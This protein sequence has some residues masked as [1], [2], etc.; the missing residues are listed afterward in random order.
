MNNLDKKR[1]YGELL[2][3]TAAVLWGSCFSFQKQ[4]MNFYGPFTLGA[5]RFFLG[6]IILIP[7]IF[8]FAKIKLRITDA[9]VDD[10]FRNKTLWTGGLISALVLFSAVTLQQVGL[11][12]TTA[13][14]AAFLTS[15]E[16][17]VVEVIGSFLVRRFNIK[18]FFGICFAI[19]GM[20]LLCVKNGLSLQLGDVLELAGA[21]FWGIQILLAD[22]YSK[23]TDAIKFSFI[24]FILVGLFSAVGMILFEK[25]DMNDI[26]SGAVPI[27]Y[28]AVIEVALCFTLQIIGQKYVPPVITAVTLSLESVFA[29]I[30]G[31]LI[32]NETINGREINGMVLMLISV[33]VLHIPIRRKGNT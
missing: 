8:L 14:K 16:I 2:L 21:F 26:I 3:L 19:I 4:G 11:V 31:A 13:G 28:T 29:V 9:S 27:L 25:P 20:Y 1:L 6:G 32:L 17:V 33:M 24:Q 12:Y 7:V 30:F 15:M 23:I 18:S 10:S 22:R 5:F